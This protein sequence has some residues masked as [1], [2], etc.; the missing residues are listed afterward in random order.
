MNLDEPLE[1]RMR[2]QPLRPVPVEWREEI[3]NSARA[4]A[5]TA[6]SSGP[7]PASTWF[8]LRRV[9]LAALI[10]PNPRAWAALGSVWVVILGLHLSARDLV[11]SEGAPRTPSASVQMRQMLKQQAQMFTE[12][13]GPSADPG[14]TM[15]KK[16]PG[17][18][19][20]QRPDHVQ[21][22]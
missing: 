18:P 4:A 21:N 10:W 16:T 9:R 6:G 11:P 12:L 2:A 17:Q 3:L 20:T 15:P 22:T 19:R 8:G 5:S 1:R 13:L 7:A 14:P